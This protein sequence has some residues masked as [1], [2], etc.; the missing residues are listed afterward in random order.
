[1]KA[2]IGFDEG[3]ALVLKHSL[4]PKTITLDLMKS[5]GMM[6][7]GN[8]KSP[9]DSPPFDQSAMDGYAFRYKDYLL[10]KPLEMI[11]TVRAGDGSSFRW[12]QGA[13]VR[14]FTGAPLPPGA[15]TVVMQ[16]KVSVADRMILVKDAGIKKGAN[17]R[18]KASH[19]WSG[20]VIAK[21][22]LRL[23]APAIAYLASAGVDAVKVYA[24]LT[25][26]VIVTGDELTPPGKKLPEGHVYECNSYALKTA[27]SAV[28][29]GTIVKIYKVKDTAEATRKAIDR[30]LSEND[31]VLITGGVSVG[32][33]DFVLPALKASG[34]RMI[35][36]KLLQKPGKPVCFGMKG[37]K[38]VFGLPGNP[39]SVLSCFY[40]LVVPAW[41]KSCG[42]R[43][44]EYLR[45]PLKNTQ[46]SKPGLTRFLKAMVTD[47]SVAI[48]PDQESYKLNSFAVANALVKLPEAVSE[49]KSGE[50]VDVIMLPL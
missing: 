7:A 38:M 5:A 11:N 40:T 8:C 26:G 35:F 18:R 46:S 28:M 47:N 29:Q 16:E 36:H 44:V 37:Q 14:I 22:G 23:T 33:F 32:E 6:L 19:V 1:M 30:A 49:V 4:R 9:S 27:V 42:A 12:K 50:W 48:L 39:A 3:L 15:D 43:P 10:G 13:C 45:L 20:K 17:V 41:M 31:C 34:V 21:T 25:V 24:P 2:L